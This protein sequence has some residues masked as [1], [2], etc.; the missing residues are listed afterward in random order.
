MDEHIDSV[1]DLLTELIT[2]HG[3]FHAKLHF[4]SSRVT[5]WLVDDPYRFRLHGIA[6]LVSADVCLA[7][8]HREY[9]AD[10]VILIESIRDIL[11]CFRDLRF[12]DE[13]IYLRF[14]MLNIFNGMIGLT[15]SCDGSHYMPWQEFLDKSVG[16][17]LGPGLKPAP[18]RPRTIRVVQR[19]T[20]QAS[21]ANFA[22]CV[23]KRI[24]R[25]NPVHPAAAP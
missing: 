12:M 19:R 14:G 4:S 15:F 1:L 7:Y 6:D 20:D 16:F 17:W 25:R 23:V 2:M 9:P 21:Q 24:N 18:E 13:T 11:R 5:L 8:P 22:Y 10:A 3:V